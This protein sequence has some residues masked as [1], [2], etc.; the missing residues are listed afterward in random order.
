MDEKSR[1]RRTFVDYTGV[2]LDR[3]WSADDLTEE[4]GR[5]SSGFGASVLHHGACKAEGPSWMYLN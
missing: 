4:P 1:V 5:I 2:E 3:Y